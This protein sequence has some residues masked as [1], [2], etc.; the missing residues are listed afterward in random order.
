MIQDIRYGARMLLK[1]PGFSAVVL[2]TLALGIGVNTALFTVF[3]A[4][5]LK[6]LPITDADSMVQVE[7]VPRPGKRAWGF[8]YPDYQDYSARTRTMEGLTLIDQR[9]ATLGIE[10]E[11]KGQPQREEYGVVTASW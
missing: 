7:A 3:N 6:P 2:L 4:L 9:G 8:S 5:V 11:G 10:H 1:K